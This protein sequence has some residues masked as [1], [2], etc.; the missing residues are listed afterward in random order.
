MLGA[1]VHGAWHAGCDQQQD[2]FWPAPDQ[3]LDEIAS[4]RLGIY[5]FQ[6][7]CS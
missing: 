6:E 2:H 3:M 7:Y 4:Y 1:G 5:P